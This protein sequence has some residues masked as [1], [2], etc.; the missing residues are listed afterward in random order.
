MKRIEDKI[1]EIEKKDKTN[2]H[3]YI[4]VVS[5]IALLML[6]V[7]YFGREISKHEGT[8]AKNMVT[9]SEQEVEQHETYQKLLASHNSLKMSLRPNE[10]WNH[11]K[12]ENTV[13]AYISYI[14][15]D[16]GIDK[17]EYLPKAIDS[18]KSSSSRAIGFKGWLFVGSKSTSGIYAS[19]NIVEVVYRDGAPVE[20]NL[21]N[22]EI[23]KGD[24]VKLTKTINRSIYKSKYCLDK[25]RCAKN[26]QGWRNKTKG[27]VTDVWK[28][29]GS[30]EFIIEIKYY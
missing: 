16:W 26:S 8:I 29:P 25:N 30:N 9:I 23:K 21:K 3:L 18:L 4:G 12:K 2:R 19:R 28:K 13:E 15:N 7:Y 6:S 11:I 10:Y 1:R 14:T 20:S 22:S 24:I 17:T 27:F 5:L